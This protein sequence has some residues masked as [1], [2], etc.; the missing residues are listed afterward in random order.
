MG[1]SSCAGCDDH[2]VELHRQ[3]GRSSQ[4]TARSP[5]WKWNL[6]IQGPLEMHLNK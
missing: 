3:L 6:E 4:E 1:K 2:E 5:A